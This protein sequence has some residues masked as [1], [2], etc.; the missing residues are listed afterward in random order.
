[1]EIRCGM[2]KL[3]DREKKYVHMLNATLCATGRA[4]CCLLE[5]YQEA[6]GVRIPEVLVPF[7]GGITFLPFVRDSKPADKSA[8]A[9]DKKK[10]AAAGTSEKKKEDKPKAEKPAAAAP[11][12]AA[13]VAEVTA[14]L[15]GA[16]VAPPA[17]PV[18]EDKPKAE[19]APKID[20]SR[21]PAV[22]ILPPKYTTPAPAKQAAAGA[23]TISATTV[24]SAEEVLAASAD[25]SNSAWLSA[26]DARLA[27]FSYVAGFQPGAADARLVSAVVAAGA[28]VEGHVNVARWLRSVQSF[29]AE[30]RAQWA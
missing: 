18:K 3:G 1:M 2:K 15:A 6:D 30:E 14:A 13:P 25:A 22:P 17:A 29:A 8:A 19:K 12:V 28:S 10:E 4:I 7:M 20:L 24:P 9:G 5:T 23:A 11:V 16:T 27:Y 21:P 26:L